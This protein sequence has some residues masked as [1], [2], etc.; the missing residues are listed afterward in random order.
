MH[1]AEQIWQTWRSHPLFREVLHTYPAYA[2]MATPYVVADTANI[3]A[4]LSSRLGR[5]Y[6]LNN[7][8]VLNKLGLIGN[9]LLA[10]RE[11]KHVYQITAELVLFVD[12]RDGNG[13][14]KVLKSRRLGCSWNGQT[15]AVPTG[16]VIPSDL[17]DDLVCERLDL[18]SPRVIVPE[19]SR[20]R[21][22]SESFKKF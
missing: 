1:P 22:V 15:V 12:H 10:Y 2:N 4:H 11:N 17:F 14:I 16:T 9:S 6:T 19:A 7:M 20:P 3:V 21:L 18:S 5:N 13:Q 8:D